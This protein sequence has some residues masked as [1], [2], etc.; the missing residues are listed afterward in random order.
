M[1]FVKTAVAAG[2]LAFVMTASA[3]THNVRVTIPFKFG[4]ANQTLPAG[5]Y[6]FKMDRAHTRIELQS[7]DGAAQFYVPVMSEQKADVESGAA[8]VFA[9]YGSTHFLK[10]VKPAN[11][12]DGWNLFQ[13]RA[14]R[15]VA[16]T[17]PQTTTQIALAR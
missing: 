15:E 1:K 4:V 9:T 2:L 6:L 13:S 14:E 10:T 7:V 3:Q 12:P 5:E 16:K 17:S 8:L 11:S